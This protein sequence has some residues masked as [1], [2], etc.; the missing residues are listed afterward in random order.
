MTGNTECIKK[1]VLIFL[2][3]FFSVFLLFPG[4]GQDDQSLNDKSAVQKKIRILKKISGA[5]KHDWGQLGKSKTEV[6]MLRNKAR[7]AIL[8]NVGV[9]MFKG[10]ANVIQK[11][12]DTPSPDGLLQDLL[13]EILFETEPEPEEK[14]MIQFWMKRNFL[15]R[16]RLRETYKLLERVLRAPLERFDDGRESFP[17]TEE[18]WKESDEKPDSYLKRIT[19]RLNVI[20][21]I[22]MELFGQID[23]EMGEL[24][25]ERSEVEDEIV[26]L[27]S[28]KESLDIAG[29]EEQ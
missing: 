23:K 15:R 17:Y 24:E 6:G 21:Y 5:Y 28:E 29:T 9:V 14:E 11:F 3:L 13:Q 4:S 26:R 27:R 2:F 19:R 10:M 16:K 20:V 8:S 1:F 12:F 25:K 22:S 18:L 7:Q